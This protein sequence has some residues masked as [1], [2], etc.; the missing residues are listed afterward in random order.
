M[1]AQGRRQA[2]KD[3]RKAKKMLEKKI[4]WILLSRKEKA[5]DEYRQI[6]KEQKAVRMAA[7]AVNRRLIVTAQAQTVAFIT[8][9]DEEAEA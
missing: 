8:S 3:Y 2:K 4:E 7:D 1:L 9:S 6:Q 5:K